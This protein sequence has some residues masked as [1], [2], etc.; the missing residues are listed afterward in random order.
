MTFGAVFA[1]TG[2]VPK[3]TESERSVPAIAHRLRITRIAIGINQ[4]E[5]CKRTGISKNTYNQWERGKGR[6][7]LDKAFLLCINLGYTLDWIYLGDPSGLPAWIARS[8]APVAS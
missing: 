8:L 6:P 3:A 7:E 1:L 5:L 2:G 4:T